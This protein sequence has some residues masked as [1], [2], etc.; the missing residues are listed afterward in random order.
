MTF[1]LWLSATLFGAIFRRLYGWR[2]SNWLM[3]IIYIITVSGLII[4]ATNN[5]YYIIPVSIVGM[6]WRFGFKDWSSWFHMSYHYTRFT[7]L[8]AAATALVCQN[9]LALL[10]APVGLIGLS[11]PILNRVVPRRNGVPQWDYKAVGEYINGAIITGEL[12]GIAL[13]LS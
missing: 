11:L 2:F 6:G 10:Y 12:V 5:W 7:T 1:F 8:A 4:Y 9:T 3:V 13:L